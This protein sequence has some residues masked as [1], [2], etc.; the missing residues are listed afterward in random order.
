VRKEDHVQP[1]LRRMERREAYGV[2]FIIKSLE[3]GPTYRV[4]LPK[5]PSKDPHYR[6]LAHQ[7]PCS[8]TMSRRLPG[9][10]AEY[11]QVPGRNPPTRIF[12]ILLMDKLIVG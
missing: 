9:T 1:W 2:Y 10:W 8:L 3:Q 5:Y 6:I 4:S 7:L 12:L 11:A